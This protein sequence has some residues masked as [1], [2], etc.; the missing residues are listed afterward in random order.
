[1]DRR[2]ALMVGAAGVVVL[3]LPA[4]FYFKGASYDPALG[5][6]TVLYRI[7]EDGPELQ[8]VGIQ[9]RELFPEENS[10]RKLLKLLTGDTP[11][12]EKEMAA[13]IEKQVHDD[14]RENR[15]VMIDGWM[16]SVTE[17][18]QCALFSI[19]NPTP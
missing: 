12:D 6:A 5:K 10:R 13:V 11:R 15:I 1:M 4:W 8:N 17:A 3:T 14:Y 18:R 16:L 7:W 19:D 2:K 9:Y